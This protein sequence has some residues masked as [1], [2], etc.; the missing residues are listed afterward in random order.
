MATFKNASPLLFILLLLCWAH[1]QVGMGVMVGGLL[2]KAP[3]V[4]TMFAYM[5]VLSVP[6]ISV[7]LNSATAGLTYDYPTSMLW[8]APM[9]F[10]RATSLILQYG[11]SEVTGS[12]GLALA[13]LLVDGWLMLAGRYARLLLLC[14][15]ACFLSCC[16]LYTQTLIIRQIPVD[17]HNSG[18]ISFISHCLVSVTTVGIFAHCTLPDD[19]WQPWRPSWWHW[20]WRAMLPFLSQAKPQPTLQLQDQG[21]DLKAP[22]IVNSVSRAAG[23]GAAGGGVGT[24]A[25]EETDREFLRLMDLDVSSE[26]Q[27][28]ERRLVKD[29][30]DCNRLTD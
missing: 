14:F 26:E 15:F 16:P 22:L 29:R 8:W 13:M 12:L 10:T 3:K 30:Y 17:I 1:A 28:V 2:Y 21:S 4:A 24:T 9:A 7:T 18:N 11:G 6:I 5:L 23:A 27:R 19:K 25:V 20:N